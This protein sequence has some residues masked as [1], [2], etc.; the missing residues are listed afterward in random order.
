MIDTVDW[1]NYPTPEYSIK[2]KFHCFFAMPNSSYRMH[3]LL[4]STL[5]FCCAA[6]GFAA[7]L[8]AGTYYPQHPEVLQMVDRAVA[9]M[10]ALSDSQIL[11]NQ[12]GGEEFHIVMLAMAHF[13]ARHDPE[14]TLVKRGIAR[15]KELAVAARNARNGIQDPNEGVKDKSN[16]ALAVCIILLCDVDAEAY[17]NEIGWLRD[18][19]LASQ[20]PTGGFGYPSEQEGI[21]LQAQYVILAIWTMKEKGIKVPAAVVN[22][23][24]E[25]LL[26]VQDVSGAWPYRATDPGPSQGLIE[27]GKRYMTH[28]TALGGGSSVLIVG[29]FFGLWDASADGQQKGILPGMPPAVK[30]ADKKAALQVNSSG[31]TVG[32]SEIF[33]A[34]ERMNQYRQQVSYDQSGSNWHY[35]A[36][37]TQERFESFYAL[38]TTAADPDTSWYDAGVERLKRNQAPSG[39][40]GINDRTE[41][42]PAVATSFAILF[43]TRGTQQ[44]IAASSGA[45]AGGQGLP[46]DTTDIRVDGTQ[47]KGRPVAAAVDQMLDLLEDDAGDLEGKSIPEDLQLAAD[48]A[49]RRAQLDRLQR[50]VRGSQSWQARR[51]A[52]RLLG[53]SDEMR[54]VPALIYALS[55]PDTTVRRYARD[56][57]RFISRKFEGFGMP[58]EPNDGE[59]ERAQEQWRQW[60]LTINPKY[61]FLNE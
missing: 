1:S 37:Y 47:I 46:K 33:E 59:L 58:D 56:G 55:D 60:Y 11:Q 49:E 2:V 34:V 28:S 45:L 54:V 39:G 42:P 4:I 15:A 25:W 14:A 12:W 16:Y 13:K 40:W 3:Y 36:L 21:T 50:L 38:A 10:E 8:G 24:Q 17:Q 43:L 52:A 19:M 44:S 48:P 51:V 20:K 61:V 29:D 23:T 26:R 22:R 41:S 18:A 9:Y 7:P 57:L 35:Y 27:Q 30:F 53:E 32:A 5:V 6:M 31:T